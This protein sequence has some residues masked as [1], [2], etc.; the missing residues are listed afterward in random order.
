ME[1]ASLCIRAWL[2]VPLADPGHPLRGVNTG[3]STPGRGCGAAL[4]ARLRA[5][6]ARARGEG[7]QRSD[8]CVHALRTWSWPC[9][10]PSRRPHRAAPH[11]RP[12]TRP[13]G[14]DCHARARPDGPSAIQPEFHRSPQTR[15]TASRE[16]RRK[17]GA[18]PDE[19]PPKGAPQRPEFTRTA[20]APSEVIAKSS[21]RSYP[22]RSA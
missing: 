15:L 2:Y 1:A 7:A 21:F 4:Y 12:A 13:P 3:L 16:S 5:S 22:S 18:P 8:V 6:R 14:L 20:H 19:K 10:V 17:H 11:G 9:C